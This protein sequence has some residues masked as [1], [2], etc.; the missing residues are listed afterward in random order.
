VELPD[1]E[2]CEI[3]A[4]PNGKFIMG[5]DDQG[6]NPR[7]E[8]ALNY[9]FR[10]SKYPIT[11]KQYQAFIDSGDYANPQWWQ[12]F[13]EEYQ[14]Q[15]MTAQYFRYANHPRDRVSWYQAVAFTRWLTVLYRAQGGLLN[16]N[17]EVRLP[18]EKEWE[19]AARG[20]EE[21]VYPYG[22]KFDETK[23]NTWETGIAMTSAVGLFADGASPF[24]VQDMSGNVW[25]WCLNKYDDLEDT[26]I[27]KSTR[28]LRGGA[29]GLNSVNA[30]CVSR[31]NYSPSHNFSRNLGFRVVAPLIS[32]SAL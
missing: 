18:T 17:E 8:V 16:P 19:Y 29:Y 25:E 2:W 32:A 7:R 13:P 30:A 23:G 31:V 5:A 20:T 1:I 15:P 27:D 26:S 28:S 21:R 4:P 9:G 11:Y 6:R 12:G 24:G 14:P 3:P 10:M 22:N